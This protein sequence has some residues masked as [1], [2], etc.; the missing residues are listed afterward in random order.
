[1]KLAHE[2]R[3]ERLRH[4]ET[5]HDG[6]VSRRH[7]PGVGAHQLVPPRGGSR[8]ASGPSSMPI[9][10]TAPPSSCRNGVL[11]CHVDTIERRWV[12]PAALAR[13]QALDPRPACPPGAPRSV[14]FVWEASPVG[15]CNLRSLESANAIQISQTKRDTTE[16]ATRT[17]HGPSHR[18]IGIVD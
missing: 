1:V 2:G 3:L 10:A 16:T 8:P 5:N 9:R 4:P 14:S 15:V 7:A 18:V 12:F 13:S 11:G 6:N 17:R